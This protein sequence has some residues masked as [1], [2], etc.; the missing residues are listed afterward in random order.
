[1]LTFTF[2]QVRLIRSIRAGVEA[3]IIIK[4]LGITTLL[5]TNTIDW[6]SDAIF[7]CSPCAFSTGRVTF[8]AGRS[9]HSWVF[10]LEDSIMAR[11]TNCTRPYL[12]VAPHSFHRISQNS[13]QGSCRYRSSCYKYLRTSNRG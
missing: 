9:S 10:S 12:L 5:S 7:A 3:L 13:C 11:I 8:S 6:T 2:Q 1:M 4:E